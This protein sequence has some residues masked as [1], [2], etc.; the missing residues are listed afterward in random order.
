MQVQEVSVSRGAVAGPG[1]P[2]VPAADE[3]PFHGGDAGEASY[4][5]KSRLNRYISCP[6]SYFIGYELKIRP[7]RP[8]M[9]FLVGLSTHRLVA[10]HHL[11]R[12]KEEF[13][14]AHVLLDKFWSRYTRG[15]DDAA[16]HREMEAARNES[17]RYAELFICNAPLDPLEIEHEFSIPIV[18][19][20]NGDTLPVPLVGIID[21]VDQPDGALRPLEIKTRARKADVWQARVS[22]ELTCYAYRVRQRLIAASREEPEKIPVGYINIIKTKTPVIQWQTDHR[23]IEDFLDLYRTAKAVYENIREGRFYQ[24]PGTHCNWCDFPSVCAKKK[25]EVVRLFGDA[26]YLRLWEE[27]L[28]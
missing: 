10:A 1:A 13:V 14:D 6:R 7:L 19:L 27:D 26:A 16:M 11:A 15:V 21:L 17:L 9:D 28:I 8:N 2:F 24:N 20:D 18:N 12:K 22:L 3:S 23:T 25:D 4:L 5:S